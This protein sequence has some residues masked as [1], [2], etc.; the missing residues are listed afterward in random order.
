[1]GSVCNGATFPHEII[2]YIFIP[3]RSNSKQPIFKTGGVKIT[4]V[5]GDKVAIPSKQKEAVRKME[6]PAYY[7]AQA[8]NDFEKRTRHLEGRSERESR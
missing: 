4:K 5:T 1:L 7:E 3:Y 8:D 6:S 2:A